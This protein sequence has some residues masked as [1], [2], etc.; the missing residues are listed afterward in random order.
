MLR[1]SHLTTTTHQNRISVLQIGP[2][3][4]TDKAP[5]FLAHPINLRKECWLDMIRELA[6]D[7][8]CVAVDHAG[9][10]ESADAEEYGIH[11]WVQDCVEVID[12]LGLERLHAVG[13]SLGGPITVGIAAERPDRV[14]SITSLGGRLSPDPVEGANAPD[15]IGM[16]AERGRDAMF[17]DVARAAIAPGSPQELVDTVFYL[18]NSHP[19]GTIREIW[20]ATSR[21]D[22]AGWAPK[23]SCP[24]LIVNGVFDA[25]C[26]PAMGRVLADAVGGRFV[27]MAGVGHLPALEDCPG[28]LALVSPH[29]AEAELAA[30]V[31]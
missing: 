2:D 16:M 13:G 22:A 29:I 18:L 6:V 3:E 30:S 25:T 11:V 8:L 24:A 27:E 28:A 31:R 26:T 17:L 4:I 15:V 21:S 19:E 23:V 14:L 5:I 10:G 12:A 20:A 1:F 7:R 9:H